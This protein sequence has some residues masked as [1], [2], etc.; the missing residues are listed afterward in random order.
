[1]GLVFSD[2]LIDVNRKISIQVKDASL[3]EALSKLLAGTKVTFEIKNNKIYFIEKKADQQSGSRKKKVSGV[4]KDATGEP[5][6]G[7]NVVEKGVGTNGVITNLDGEFTLEVPENASLII[8]YIGYLQQDVSTKGKDAFNII[9]KE[10]TKTLDEVV[11]V[12]YGVQKK[13]NLT[14][15]VAAVDSKSLQN[16]PVTNVS[17]AIQGLLPGVTVISGRGSREVIIQP[18]GYVVS[19]L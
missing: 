16:R 7:A 14:G 13:V 3:D 1:M 19:G 17:N 12:G 8:S 9:M 2:Q 6:I 15:A 4:V 11:V 18:Y 5:I 10:D